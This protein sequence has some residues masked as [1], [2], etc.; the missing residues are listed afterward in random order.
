M[1]RRSRA[2]H[3]LFIAALLLVAHAA[4]G[5]E[6]SQYL[7]QLGLKSLLAAHLES[8][9]ETAAGEDRVELVNRLA[10]LYAELLESADDTAQQASLEERSRKL[11]AIAPA[12]SADDLRLALLRGSYRSAERIAENHRLRLDKPGEV[13]TAQETFERIIPELAGLRQSLREKIEVTERRLS[14]SIG[15]EALSLSESAERQRALKS[16]C[17]FLQAWSMYYQAWLSGARDPARAAEPLFAEVLG[18]ESSVLSPDDVSVDL[19]AAESIARSIL[20]MALCKSLSS[21]TPTALAWVELLEDPVA[22]EPLRNE[23]PAWKLS[24]LLDQGDFAQ[25]RVLLDELRQDDRELPL[26]WL[27]LVAVHALEAGHDN[28]VAGELARQMVFDLAGRSE[29]DQILD[30]ATRYGIESIGQ[31]GFALEYVKGVLAYQ[32][33]RKA[34]SSDEP[35]VDAPTVQ[36]YQTAQDALVAAL[37]QSDASKSPEAAAACRRLIAWCAFFRG[38][39]LEAHQAFE[40]AA[41]D[42]DADDA[43]EARWMAIVCLDRLANAGGSDDLKA[44]LAAAIDRYLALYPANEHAAQLVLKRT[45]VSGDVSLKTVNDLLAVPPGSA[46]YESAQG[47]AADLLYR[48]FREAGAPGGDRLSLGTQYLGVEMNLIDGGGAR[49]IQADSSDARQ[50]IARCRRALEVALSDGMTE[51]AMATRVF[52]ALDDPDRVPPGDLTPFA[53]ELQFRRVQERLCVDDAAAAET[54]A[55]KLWTDEA[56]SSWSRFAARAMFG[57]GQRLARDETADDTQRARAQEI[58][59]KHG[60]RVLREFASDPQALDQPNALAYHAIVADAAFSLWQR[61]GDDDR[62]RTAMFLF[63]KLLEARPNNA[64]FLRSTAVLAGRYGSRKRALDCWRRI[65]SGTSVDSEPWFEA[66]FHVIDILA[67]LDPPRAREVM[68]QH[69]NLHPEYGPEPWGSK[70]RGLDAQIPEQP[71]DTPPSPAEDAAP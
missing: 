60:G 18:A 10:G 41:A 55:D 53:Q 50:L 8:Q 17:A 20:G 61:T 49:M 26:A 24:I 69:K 15:A 23:A 42:M 59:V 47:R 39:F 11:L 57:F 43:A 38:I 63:E 35:A 37:S 54:M 44:N 71:C 51:C 16:Q 62:G 27:R 2:C 13:Q 45:L 3:V 31:S 30:L 64:S 70:L 67:D 36:L 33:A 65:A 5:D 12:A 14:R 7:E 52:R 32:Q 66:R 6:L 4:R 48:L 25:A 21:S 68:N 19:R 58:I 40:D 29:F 46:V 56:E 22:F 1:C 28:R 34:H 9:L